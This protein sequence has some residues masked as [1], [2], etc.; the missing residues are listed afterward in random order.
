[1]RVEMRERL[2]DGEGT[3][4]FTNL[5]EPSECF[6][7]INLCAL[8]EIEPGQSVGVHSHGPDAELYYLLKG[9]LAVTDNG[10]EG[11]LE[12]GDVMFTGNGGTHSARNDSEKKATLMTVVH[13]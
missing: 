7:K 12:E 1:M 4:H 2:R 13:P 10:V 11:W 8:I 3:L 6:G 9:R 5:L